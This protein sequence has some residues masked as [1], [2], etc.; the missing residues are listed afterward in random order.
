MEFF[1]VSMISG[2]CKPPCPFSCVSFQSLLKNQL[3][4]FVQISFCKISKII[5]IKFD[6][7]PS[8]VVQCAQESGFEAGI[9]NA[10]FTQYI[11]HLRVIGHITDYPGIYRSGSAG[12]SSAIIPGIMRIVYTAGAM[13]HCIYDGSKILDQTDTF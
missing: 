4:A 6:F 2:G 8:G 10:P 9:F 3:I 12:T 5:V 11:S 13:T 1:Q 7:I